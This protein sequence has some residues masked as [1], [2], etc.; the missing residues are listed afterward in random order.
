MVLYP[1]KFRG[2]FIASPGIGT[3][4]YTV[5]SS[6]EWHIGCSPSP[7]SWFY[8]LVAIDPC[9]ATPCLNGGICMSMAADAICMCPDGFTGTHCETRKSHTSDIS[10]ISSAQN[11]KLQNNH[12]T[13]ELVSSYSE[14]SYRTSCVP[15][16]HRNRLLW[17]LALIAFVDL[18]HGLLSCI[19][20]MDSFQ[21]F[22]FIRPYYPP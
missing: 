14:L 20:V 13:L 19:I 4:S 3:H 11:I 22:Y 5:S 17:L 1:R 9:A 18:F 12:R 15:L 2:P 10:M 6:W 8:V 7:Y 21:Y 16:A